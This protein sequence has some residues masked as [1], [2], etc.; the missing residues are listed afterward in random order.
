[1]D[2]M[3]RRRRWRGIGALAVLTAA[4]ALGPLCV[5]QKVVR[6][7]ADRG[8][9]EL[10]RR[11]TAL[12]DPTT[13]GDAQRALLRAGLPSV[14]LLLA[15]VRRADATSEPAL[16]VLVALRRDAAPAVPV[17]RRMLAEA[18]TPALA[19]AVAKLAGPPVILAALY[20][21]N[22]VLELDMEGKVLRRVAANNP[23][24][25][26]PAPDD[27]LHVLEYGHGR[28]REIGWDGEQFRVMDGPKN[29]TSR[30]ELPDGSRI[31]TYFDNGGNLRRVDPTG[32]VAWSKRN[33]AIRCVC[34]FDR[35]YVALGNAGQGLIVDLDG[36]VLRTVECG[37]FCMSIRPLLDGGV[38]TTLRNGHI[39]FVD[40][41][42]E[43]VV[44]HRITSKPHDAVVLRDGRI[45]VWVF[46]NPCG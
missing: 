4:V 26:E 7:Q 43:V 18:A 28:V 32:E 22:E 40:A 6:V 42:G 9:S 11:I 34:E 20:T 3:Q 35:I 33:G 2:R 41:E 39:R 25:I 5:A 46:R 38:L 44:E 14:P 13:R 24:R 17:L 30:Y 31:E 1:M 27:R 21:D 19:D 15:A 8:D 12:A 10:E 23:W 45:V 36:N 16:Q 29:M 37:A